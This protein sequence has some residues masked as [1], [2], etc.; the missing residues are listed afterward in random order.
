LAMAAFVK[1]HAPKS[2][3]VG[4]APAGISK[5]NDIYRQIFMVKTKEEETLIGIK[6]LLEEHSQWKN[7]KEISVMFDFNPINPY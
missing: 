2:T 4:P 7:E 6:D 3:P 5:I 1:E